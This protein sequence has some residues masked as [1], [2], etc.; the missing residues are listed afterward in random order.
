[1]LIRVN[2]LNVLIKISILNVLMNMDILNVLIKMDILKL[3]KYCTKN[4]KKFKD[5]HDTEERD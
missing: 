4:G 1:M 5:L 3:K 2:I